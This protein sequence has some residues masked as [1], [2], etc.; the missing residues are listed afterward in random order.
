MDSAGIQG[1]FWGA[2]KEKIAGMERA[3]DHT[4]RS[5]PG[6]S[7]MARSLLLEYIALVNCD[8]TSEDVRDWAH[9]KRDLP[10]PPDSRSWG[11]VISSVARQGLIRAV[12]YTKMRERK[13]HQ[14]PKTVW[15]K[16]HNVE[17]P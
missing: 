1:E 11:S 15:R 3:V 2:E 5:I 17:K 14:A 12:G 13:C 8:F 16:V 10:I 9:K 7:R 4:D 6:W